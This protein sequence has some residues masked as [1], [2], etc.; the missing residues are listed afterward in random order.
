[1]ENILLVSLQRLNLYISCD[2]HLLNLLII[3][4]KDCS[5][6]L[7]KKLKQ[8]IFELVV[9][10]FFLYFSELQLPDQAKDKEVLKNFS[11]HFE[12]L[13]YFSRKEYFKLLPRAILKLIIQ[14]TLA[15]F[16]I[17]SE[18]QNVVFSDVFAQMS[19]FLKLIKTR[20]NS[21]YYN[22]AKHSRGRE[23]ERQSVQVSSFSDYKN[24]IPL[25]ELEE[26]MVARLH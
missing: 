21:F 22:E 18:F 10:S 13:L 17:N 23:L 24:C 15:G 25:E 1:M 12:V 8:H 14:I 7:R 3:V 5:F 4:L 2:K 6:K 9:D 19:Q 26:E 20:S 16:F 11:S